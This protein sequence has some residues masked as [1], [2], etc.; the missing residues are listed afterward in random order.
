M[1]WV[2]HQIQGDNGHHGQQG[3]QGEQY[4]PF[5]SMIAHIGCLIV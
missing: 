3:H 2:T 1:K 5:H 4:K